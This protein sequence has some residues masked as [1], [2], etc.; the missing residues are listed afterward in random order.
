MGWKPV[1]NK[2]GIS[3]STIIYYPNDSQH[4]FRPIHCRSMKLLKHD[5]ATNIQCGFVP[6]ITV[7]KTWLRKY[8]VDP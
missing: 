4:G 7:E 3:Y 1:N 8:K 5:T 6:K 2:Q